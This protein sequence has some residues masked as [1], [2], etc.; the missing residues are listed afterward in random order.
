MKILITI[1]IILLAAFFI[2]VGYDT[3]K[4]SQGQQ[5]ELQISKCPTCEKCPPVIPC[6]DPDPEIIT[7]YI[8]VENQEVI[9]QLNGCI[10]E[11]YRQNNEIEALKGDLQTWKNAYYECN[12]K[13]YPLELN[14]MP[15]E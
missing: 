1:L 15:Q 5:E 8:T 13:G 2:Y 12:E 10:D 9:E 14:P 6:G 4:L 11:T 3:Y 7:E